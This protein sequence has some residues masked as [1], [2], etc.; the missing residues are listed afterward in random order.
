MTWSN[1]NELLNMG[2]MI[3]IHGKSH[4][5]LS[6][7]R[8]SKELKNEIISPKRIVKKNYRWIVTILH[9]HLERVEV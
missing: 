8:N 7:I 5:R 1:L 2:H 6:S 4:K 3:G 9:S